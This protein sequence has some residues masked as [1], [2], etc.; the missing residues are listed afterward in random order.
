MVHPGKGFKEV[1][2]D[3]SRALRR[4]GA[5]EVEDVNL[6]TVLA[7]GSIDGFPSV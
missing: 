1:D 2:R 3:R 4:H 6:C 7:G 5:T